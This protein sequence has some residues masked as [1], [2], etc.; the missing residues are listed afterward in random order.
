[1]GWILGLEKLLPDFGSGSRVQKRKMHR[2]PDPD[3][4]RNTKDKHHRFDIKR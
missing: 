2:I 3:T 1:M 4:V